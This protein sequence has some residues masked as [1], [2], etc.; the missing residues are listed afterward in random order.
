M[1]IEQ[2]KMDRALLQEKVKALDIVIGMYEPSTTIATYKT[3]VISE[4]PI[5]K[6]KSKKQIYTDLILGFVSN[7]ERPVLIQEIIEGISPKMVGKSP[8]QI[9]N[10]IAPVI[11]SLINDGK[12]FTVTGSG[13]KI[14]PKKIETKKDMQLHVF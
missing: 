13:S 12:Y 7:S 6:G 8:E 10:T 4:V 1:N 11:S 3:K 9:R 14:D 2:L 5:I